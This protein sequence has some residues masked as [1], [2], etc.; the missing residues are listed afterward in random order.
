MHKQ[1]SELLNRSKASKKQIKSKTKK[2][3]TAG[4]GTLV[5][6]KPKLAVNGTRT[7][8]WDMNSMEH[9]HMMFAYVCTCIVILRLDLIDM[10][11]FTGN[12]SNTSMQTP[13]VLFDQ[14]KL[15]IPHGIF[16]VNPG[17]CLRKRNVGVGIGEMEYNHELDQSLPYIEWMDHGVWGL[18]EFPI[19]YH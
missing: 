12:W 14:T 1:V 9:T 10:Y 15:Q 19:V 13:E 4:K 6:S 3:T 17:P 7:K 18:F 2:T 8:A 11:G 5:T 16:N